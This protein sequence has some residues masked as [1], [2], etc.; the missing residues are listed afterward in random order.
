[1]ATGLVIVGS[2]IAATLFIIDLGLRLT[3]LTRLLAYEGMP[4]GYYVSDERLGYDIAKNFAT[5][6]HRF[7]DGEYS[8]WSNELGCF[9]TPYT[10]EESYILLLGDSFVWGF[11]PLESKWGTI[12]ERELGTRVL[13]C[14][15]A[16]YGTRQAL[17][18]GARLLGQLPPPTVV[19]LGYF[20]NDP[21]NDAEFPNNLVYDGQLIKNLEPDR[22]KSIQDIMAALP[23]SAE[24]SKKYCMWNEPEHPTLQ[25]AKCFLSRQSIIY[26]LI[27]NTAKS[28]ISLDTLRRFGV[29]NQPPESEQEPPYPD[30][31]EHFARIEAFASLL[32]SRGSALVV[33]LV[34]SK[35]GLDVN[36]YAEAKLAF[37]RLH[38]PYIDLAPAFRTAI[39][40]GKELFWSK[41]MHWNEAGNQLAGR[42]VSDEINRLR[43]FADDLQL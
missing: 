7:A 21:E 5:S 9:D 26:T 33:V 40:D 2:S 16:G 1:M 3:P 28:S 4:R 22:S 30:Y 34:A 41:D 15:V 39:S 8:I 24:R 37:D 36:Q 17:E 23:E 11:A 19:I 27:R 29:V 18:K 13:K 43:L 14:G 31:A 12:L 42:V 6:T 20:S 32:K 10:G 38:I 35:E 25:R